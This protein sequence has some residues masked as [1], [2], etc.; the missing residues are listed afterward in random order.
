MILSFIS[1]HL[2]WCEGSNDVLVCCRRWEVVPW[3]RRRGPLWAALFRGRH[4]GLRDHV[5]TRLQHGWRRWAS[6]HCFSQP[7]VTYR[8]STGRLTPT[9]GAPSDDAEDWDVDAAPQR[10]EVHNNMYANNDE[11]DDW[12]DVVG[13][14]VMVRLYQRGRDV[15]LIPHRRSLHILIDCFP[16][17]F[18]VQ[19]FFTRNGKV[20]GKREADLPSN[21]FY[22][23]IGMMSS[24]EKVRVE[25]HPLS[26]WL[27][28]EKGQW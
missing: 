6:S 24:G 20:V 13:R 10:S 23:T 1:T 8:S 4:Y 3:Q 19:V 28:P 15:K 22:P 12:E 11:E 7:F 26:G 2:K 5:S 18:L 9:D 16:A 21:G 14:K 27:T 25:L 17:S